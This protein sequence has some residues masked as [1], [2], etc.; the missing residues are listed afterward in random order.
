M[1]EKGTSMAKTLSPGNQLYLYRLLKTSFGIGT[2]TF[3]PRVEEAL[4]S[5]GINAADLGYG[6][7]HELMESLSDFI[8]LTDFK[9]G[10]SYVRVMS[11][12]S[13]DEALDAASDDGAPSTPSHANKPWKHRRATLKPIRPTG[14]V[15]RKGTGDPCLTAAKSAPE[16]LTPEAADSN[17]SSTDTTSLPHSFWEEV[18]CSDEFLSQLTAALPF[19]CDL[20]RLLTEDWQIACATGTVEHSRKQARFPLRYLHDDKTP[21]TVTIARRNARLHEKS[22]FVVDVDVKGVADSVCGAPCAPE[23]S[24]T[25]LS[26]SSLPHGQRRSLIYELS[27]FMRFTSW[28]ELCSS[29]ASIALREAWSLGEASGAFTVLREYFFVTLARIRQQELLVTSS[30]GMRSFWNTGLVTPAWEPIYCILI[31]AQ[32]ITPWALEGFATRQDKRLQHLSKLPERAVYPIQ[33]Q[34]VAPA[35]SFKI[36]PSIG[37]E[38]SDVTAALQ[39]SNMDWR[40]VTPVWDPQ[41]T[42]MKSLIPLH[43]D[44]GKALVVD[45][46]DS[47]PTITS[48]LDLPDAYTCARIVSPTQATWLAADKILS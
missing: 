8:E 13:F 4:M 47:V 38:P 18:H 44:A 10:R 22:W 39:R 46:I 5:D 1:I 25:Q 12:I 6:D 41:D 7:V 28:N 24:W 2:Q 29:L 9:G 23:G 31:A 30:D 48:T 42:H 26:A 11:F 27:C 16:N 40:S 17:S 32:G 15:T 14:H 3:L 21:I 33:R 43:I 19:G 37:V 45:T 20:H 36:R 35:P 34:L